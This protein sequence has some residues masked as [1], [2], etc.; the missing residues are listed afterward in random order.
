MRWHFGF[1]KTNTIMQQRQKFQRWDRIRTL[2]IFFFKYLAWNHDYPQEQRITLSKSL[3][4]LFLCHCLRLIVT[5]IFLLSLN[6]SSGS[7]CTENNDFQIIENMQ[8][9]YW[10]VIQNPTNPYTQCGIRDH[11]KQAVCY[12]DCLN[13]IY[14]S[15]M[16]YVLQKSILSRTEENKVKYFYKQ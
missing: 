7:Q 8:G 13:T 6:W 16:Y 2:F 4:P 10:T 15:C 12:W 1:N 3:S 9:C 11:F 5:G 14:L